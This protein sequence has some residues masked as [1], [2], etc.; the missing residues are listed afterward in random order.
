MQSVIE[1]HTHIDRAGVW[2]DI[3]E[4]LFHCLGK[5]E[6]HSRFFRHLKNS[7]FFEDIDA[8]NFYALFDALDNA[9]DAVDKHLNLLQDKAKHEEERKL[10]WQETVK[11]WSLGLKPAILRKHRIPQFRGVLPPHSK[12]FAS[13]NSWEQIADFKPNLDF[14]DENTTQAINAWRNACQ[15]SSEVNF[16]HQSW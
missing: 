11:A 7:T 6:D 14:S 2:E 8:N 1:H 12:W 9:L 15:E 5:I 4:H 3:R 10:Y 16:S 13:V